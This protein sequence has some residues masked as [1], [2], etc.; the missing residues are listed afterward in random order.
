MLFE[1]EFGKAKM[2]CIPV[3]LHKAGDWA[4][5]E[6]RDSLGYAGPIN[7]K[8]GHFSGLPRLPQFPFNGG[9]I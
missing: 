8:P 6:W 1:V 5:L 9:L 4:I 7:I 3:Q 2:L